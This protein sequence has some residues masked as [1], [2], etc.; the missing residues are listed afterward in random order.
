MS[1]FDRSSIATYVVERLTSCRPQLQRQWRRD[2]IS[3]LLVDDLLPP[4]TAR[5]LFDAFPAPE[6]LTALRNLRESRYVGSRLDSYQ[7]LLREAICAFADPRVREAISGITELTGLLP[8][9]AGA[10][11]VSRMAR[12]GFLNPNAP[13]KTRG[14]FGRVLSLSYYLTPDLRLADGGHLELWHDGPDGEPTTILSKFN[15]LVVM[16]AH[17]NAWH[18][19]SPLRTQRGRCCIWNYYYAALG[20]R[21]ANDNAGYEHDVAPFRGRPEQRFRDLLL[22]ADTFARQSMYRLALERRAAAAREQEVARAIGRTAAE[23][24]QDGES[25]AAE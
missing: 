8:P 12:G 24:E 3:N 15:R 18:S 9:E 22:R 19:V 16:A 13:S 17:G 7:P 4:E 1:P 6:R 21:P 25:I 2:P 14:G 23:L 11:G 10:S 20:V 5:A